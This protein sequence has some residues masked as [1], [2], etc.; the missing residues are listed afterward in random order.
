ME[1]EGIL[2][3]KINGGKNIL[4]KELLP[5]ME[6][7]KKLMKKDGD[8]QC[9]EDLAQ[10][11][12]GG[13]GYCRV[14]MKEP[15]CCCAAEDL[16]MDEMQCLEMACAPKGSRVHM[17]AEGLKDQM[18]GP[19]MVGWKTIWPDPYETCPQRHKNFVKVPMSPVQGHEG[20]L[21]SCDRKVT[22]SLGSVFHRVRKTMEL[23]VEADFELPC[24]AGKVMYRR[25]KGWHIAG[26]EFS[27]PAG[28]KSNLPGDPGND[29]RCK[30]D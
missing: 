11:I 28:F 2:G 17:I 27:C 30:C 22:R 16:D 20:V 19:I 10:A 24:P 4:P 18:D 15:L 1:P 26:N 3:A 8:L 9:E 12:A 7:I 14:R 23:C 13:S 21:K 25:I 6:G 5:E 29:S